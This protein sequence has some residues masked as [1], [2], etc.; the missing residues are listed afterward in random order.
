[1]KT[2]SYALLL[3]NLLTVFF[4]ASLTGCGSGT[5]NTPPPAL[6]I[7]IS[8]GAANVQWGGSIPLTATVE[9][10]SSNSGVTWSITCSSTPCGSLSATST[11]GGKPTT[12]SPPV[13]LPATNLTVNLKASSVADSTKS[14]TAVITVPQLSGFAGVREAH[15]DSVNGVTRLIIN[16]QPA[17][18]LMFMFQENYLDCSG[19]GDCSQRLQYLAPQVQDAATSGI[20]LFQVSLQGW[21]WDNQGTAPLDFSQIDQ[22]MDNLLAADPKALLILRVID[23]PGPGWLPPV[24]PTNADYVVS[25]NVPF[26]TGPGQISMASDI[27]FNGFLTSIPHLIDH[28]VNSS[29]GAHV[30]GY[31]IL[32]PPGD[33]EWY[34]VGDYYGPDYSPVSTQHFQSWLQSKYGSDAALSAAWGF[35]VTI[36]TA[37]ASW[38]PAVPMSIAPQASPAFNSPSPMAFRRAPA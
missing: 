19:T 13:A 14:A 15:I 8:P 5:Q 37:L 7:A 20:D 35:P 25:P 31:T 4:V 27:F 36:A 1:M 12:Y 22:L 16:G 9:N 17:P 3:G 18:P 28:L 24:A 34:P 21:P 11:A 32:C 6:S 2:P 30:L 26:S 33:G 38:A 29:Y 23:T 10:D